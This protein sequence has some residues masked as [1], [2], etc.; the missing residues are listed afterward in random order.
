[1]SSLSKNQKLIVIL[2]GISNVIMILLLCVAVTYSLRNLSPPPQDHSALL[3]TSGPTSIPSETPVATWT[4]T[5]TPTPYAK[6]TP[7]L[8]PLKEED[9]ETLDA[10][11]W[12]VA[13]LRGLTPLRP[14][15]RYRISTQQLRW[16]FTE[17]FIGEQAAEEARTQVLILSTLDF[18]PPHTDLLELWEIGFTEGIAGFYLPETEEI[19]IITGDYSVGAME[20]IVFAH[21]YGHALVDQ[22]FD[23]ET[24][25]LDVTGDLESTDRLLGI[26]ALV[27][28]DATLVE[29]QWIYAHLTQADALEIWNDIVRGII[30]SP[31]PTEPVPRILGELSTFPYTYGKAFVVALHDQQGWP[32]VNAAYANP[33]ISTEHILHPERYLAGDQPIPISLIPLTDTLGSDWQ[34]IHDDTGGEFFIRLYL[35]NYLEGSEALRAA[36]GWGGDRCSAYYNES[37]EQTVV[38]WRLAWDTVSDSNE[39]FDTY[40]DYGDA[41]FGFPAGDITD[42][43]WI[44]WEGRDAL[45]ASKNGDRVTL[46][47]GPN[48]G[49]VDRVL[50]TVASE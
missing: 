21:E 47:I 41:R 13:G 44:C 25:G 46:V 4:P 22:H 9:A 16:R 34:L 49:L 50:V 6:L 43:G 14:V 38:V 45:C 48:R 12:D 35:E 17:M 27:E 31:N 30:H 8:K 42:E 5:P 18:M 29:E 33:P 24:L 1:M 28:G 3:P 2:M 26:K 7:T 40:G 19:Y 39:F 10:V 23:L 20:R 37:T 32:A 36:E 15:A 11:E